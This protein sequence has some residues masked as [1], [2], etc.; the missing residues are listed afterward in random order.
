M[1]CLFIYDYVHVMGSGFVTSQQKTV[2]VCLSNSM[3]R[4]YNS[5]IAL[6]RLNGTGSRRRQEC[7]LK[8]K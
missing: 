7:F 4:S 3:K 8:R 6:K 1:K 5:S 2:S